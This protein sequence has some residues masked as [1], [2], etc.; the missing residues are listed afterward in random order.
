MVFRDNNK[1]GNYDAGTDAGIDGVLVNLYRDNGNGTLDAGDTFVTNF[2]TAGGGLYLFNNLCSGDYIVQIPSTEFGTGKALNGLISSPGGTTS[3]PD[4]NTDNDDNGQDAINGSIASQAI[5]LAYNVSDVEN[6]TT[7]DF[8]F[9]TPTLVSINDVTLNEGNGGGTTTFTFTVTRDNTDDAFSLAVNTNNVTTNSSD[10][11]PISGGTVNFTT[12]GSLT[13][14]VSV[15]VGADEVVE[16]NETFNVVLSGAPYGIILTKA[17][18][19]GTIN[20]DDQAVLSINSVSNL[21]GNSGT[22]IYT[23]TITADKTV[24]VSYTVS[25]ATSNGTASA[26]SDYVSNNAVINFTGIAGESHTF[27]VTVNGD[28]LVEPNETFNVLLSGVNASARNV[29]VSISSGTGTGTIS[30][31]DN[32]QMTINDVSLIEG[33]GGNTNF[34]FTVTLDNPVSS[35]VNV[36]YATAAGTATAGTDYTTTSGTLTFNPGETSKTITVPV[37]GDAVGESNET[38]FVNLTNLVVGGGLLSSVNI[39]DAQGLGTILDDDLQ[40]FINDVTAVETDAGTTNFTFTVHR[41]STAT[42]ETIDYAT[43]DNT[44]TTADNDYTSAS[45]T[46]SFAI[47]EA[48]KTITVSVKGDTKVENNE[49]FVV[50]LTNASNGAISDGQGQGTITNDDFASLTLSSPAAQNEGAAGTVAYTF[51]VM[52]DKNMA[53]G[54]TVNY[55]TN[56]VTATTADNDYDDN[57]GTLTFTGTAGETRTITVL[58]RGDTKVE[59]DETFMVT[60]NSVTGPL[61]SSI[62]VPSPSQTAT[63]TNDDAATVSL[64]GNVSQSEAIT[65]QTFTVNLSNPV[66]VD[67]TVNF[68]TSNDA[69]TIAD[70]DYTAVNQTVTFLAGTTT[71]QTVDVAITNDNKVEAN[72]DY[73]VTLSAL[74][75]SGRSVSFGTTLGTG[76]ISN[77]DAATVTLTGTI[78]KAEGNTGTVDY[79]FTAT[80]NNPVQDG[81]TVAYTTADGTAL[82]SDNDYSAKTG[83]LTFLGNANEAHQIVVTTNGDLK[84]ENNETFTLALGA[85]TGAPTGVTVGG[86][87]QTGTIENDELDW[88]DA[89]TTAQSGF[90]SSYPTTLVDNGARHKLAPGGVFLGTTVSADLDGQP[91]S[92]ASGDVTGDDGVTLPSAFIINTTGSVTVTAS[93]VSKLDAWIDFNRDGDWDDANEKVANGVSLVVGSNTVPINVPAASLGTSYARFRVSTS[94]GLSPTGEATD[95]EVEDYQVTILNN[96]FA[97]TSPSVTEGNT[98]TTNLTYTISRTTNS[99]ASSV[100]YEITGGTATSGSDYVALA[101]GT[102]NFLAGGALTQDITVVVNGDVVV[103][104]NETVIVTLSSLV[105]GAISTGTGTGTINNDD[106]TTLTLSG[107]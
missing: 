87:G 35:T 2:T 46:L 62:N 28:V 72:E 97:I 24:D 81:F 30:N 66:D 5:T 54:F 18:G 91:T 74:S 73:N 21:E 50:N 92:T 89:P 19:V 8:G 60:I 100:A 104:N 37:A 96:Q 53:S 29:I 102:V 68:A 67:V 20:N 3:D 22:Q 65:P 47:G 14:T 61:S 98:G 49:T 107:G 7:L 80:L 25:V 45:G 59:L 12:G 55:S 23:F 69:A 9:R 39:T 101:L 70:N 58:A 84:I 90:A 1:D 51:N 17:T 85:I 33:S 34:V 105:N 36:N 79:T 40:F 103:E 56:N 86:T 88:G 4:D 27:N 42:A 13:T 44:A 52:L 106:A 94:G 95:G 11:T 26:A 76:T 93:A 63:I 75:A 82:V 64:A 78:A 6:N 38:F 43:A 83:S 48:D 41:T 77:D 57:D 16:L 99:T 71:A 10:F 15:T 32:S 31:D